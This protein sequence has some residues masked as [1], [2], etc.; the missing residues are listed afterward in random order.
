MITSCFNGQKS[1]TM[2]SQNK[3]AFQKTDSGTS[4]ITAEIVT[5]SFIE[6]PSV[7]D[8]ENPGQKVYVKKLDDYFVRLSVQDYFIKFCEGSVTINELDAA[9][10]RQK[11]EIKTLK[12]EVSF[13]KGSWDIC[14]EPEH[15]QQTREGKYI[16]LWKIIE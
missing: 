12:M 1:A 5:H 16:V 15:H 4:I 2:V 11:A 3:T 6:P 8:T 14:H 10:S 9:L 7:K 13:K